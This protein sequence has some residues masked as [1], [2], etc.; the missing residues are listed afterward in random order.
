MTKEAQDVV[1][2]ILIDAQLRVLAQ[3]RLV[4]R[5]QALIEGYYKSWGQITY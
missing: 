1:I 2:E 5:L 4:W 3:S